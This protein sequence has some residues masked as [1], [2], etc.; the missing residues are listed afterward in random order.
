MRDDSSA[1][2]LADTVARDRRRIAEGQR[3]TYRATWVVGVDGSVDVRVVE[4]PIVH[5]L[6]PDPAFVSDGARMVIARTLRVAPGT[7]DVVV[8]PASAGD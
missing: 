1:N 6:V 8:A 3:P 7:F 2:R 4:L 5:L